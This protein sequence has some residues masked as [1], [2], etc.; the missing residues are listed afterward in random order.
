MGEGVYIEPPFR[1]DYGKNIHLGNLIRVS[2]FSFGDRYCLIGKNVQMNFNCCILDCNTVTI[3]DD[4]LIA[5]N[6]GVRLSF[7]EIDP[8]I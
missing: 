8:G 1:C 7:M 3:G 2:F 5:P 4:C 6:V